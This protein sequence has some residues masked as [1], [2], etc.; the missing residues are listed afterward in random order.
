[1]LLEPAIG[2][3]VIEGL[4]EAFQQPMASRI[5]CCEVVDTL[6]GVGAVAASSSR[7]LDL[8]QHTIAALE[9][10]DIHLGHR[11][12]QVD[13]EEESC[14]SAAYDCCSHGAKIMKINEK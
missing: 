14:R 1:M 7:Y 5:D 12:L 9:D 8:C 4:E 10:G 3:M 11:L 2:I 13:G 6:E